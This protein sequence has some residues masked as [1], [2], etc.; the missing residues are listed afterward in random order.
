MSGDSHIRKSSDSPF[1]N[2][3]T[4]I[5]LDSPL[6]TCQYPF[7]LSAQSRT[8][9]LA[10]FEEI[11]SACLSSI[12][13]LKKFILTPRRECFSYAIKSKVYKNADPLRT[14][15]SARDSLPPRYL[16]SLSFG[17][18]SLS[19][20]SILWDYRNA[21]IEKAGRAGFDLIVVHIE[22]ASKV[23]PTKDAISLLLRKFMGIEFLAIQQSSNLADIGLSNIRTDVTNLN[24]QRAPASLST[25]EDLSELIQQRVLKNLAV[26]KKC[27]GMI[28]G[29][30]VTR[31]AA[32][33]LGETSKGRGGAIAQWLSSDHTLSETPCLFPLRDLSYSEISEY[34]RQDCSL[35]EIIDT[36][37]SSDVEKPASDGN[38]SINDLVRDYCQSLEE[39]FPAILA[40]VVK[41]SGKLRSHYSDDYKCG[42]CLMLTDKAKQSGLCHGCS[43]LFT[44]DEA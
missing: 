41:T 38:Y 7:A 42:L 29:D 19:L 40:N 30:T 11:F 5:H 20:L 37:R 8:Q 1:R 21:Q 33:V 17:A 28:Y 43:I 23:E 36:Y 27:H 26:Q 22:D 35:S 39:G 14:R 32:R 9:T 25:Q 2:S 44:G 24:G 13:L 4:F 16:L 15:H 12:H 3:Q 6:S 10:V 31:L 34:L 18:A